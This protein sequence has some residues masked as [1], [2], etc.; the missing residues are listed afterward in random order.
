MNREPASYLNQISKDNCGQCNKPRGDHSKK[1]MIR[2][3]A[4]ADGSLYQAIL[5][6]QSLKKQIGEKE[7]ESGSKDNPN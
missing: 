4:K 6:N 5:E 1:N 3:M 2:C 7:N